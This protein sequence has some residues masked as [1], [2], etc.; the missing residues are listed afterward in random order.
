MVHLPKRT[1]NQTTAGASEAAIM[2]AEILRFYKTLGIAPK[3]AES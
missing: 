2:T 1:R 3:G